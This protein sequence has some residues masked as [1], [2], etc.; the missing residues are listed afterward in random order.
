VASWL[1]PAIVF[2]GLSSGLL[3]ATF[4]YVWASH[5][6]RRYV[7]LWALAWLAAIPQLGATWLL[8]D[9]PDRGVWTCQQLLLTLNAFLM[10]AGC[11]DFVHS[12]AR[13]RRLF[14]W[15]LPFVLWAVFGP[16]LTD[17]FLELAL[18][19]ALLLAG[20][21]LWT[22][23]RF[24]GVSR[25]RDTRVA[26]TVGVLFAVAGLHELDFPLLGQS[27]WA[28]PIGYTVAS[29]LAISISVLLLVMILEE[30]RQEVVMERARL[31]GI[32][33]H[34]PVG[35]L[36]AG[37]HGEVVFVN[38]VAKNR[39]GP[40][41][42]PTTARELETRL[43][44]GADGALLEDPPLARVLATGSVHPAR[45]YLQPGSD[46]RL[47]AVAVNAAPLRDARGALIGAVAAFQDLDEIKTMQLEISRTE[48]LRGLG[49]VAAG[50]A[51]DFNNVL[52]VIVGHAE[53]AL[54]ATADAALRQPLLRIRD[55]AT[56]AAA[57]AKRLQNLARVRQGLDDAVV[58]LGGVVREAVEL[59]RPRWRDAAQE[60]GIAYDVRCELA[61]DVAAIVGDPDEL[62]E[63]VFNLVFNALDAMPGGGS[64]VC[65][66]TTEAGQAVLTLSDSGAGM[67]PAVL[68]RVFEPFFTTKGTGGTGLGLAVVF[69]IVERHDGT[70]SVTS[71]PGHGTTFTL[72]F[73]LVE[74]RRANV[75]ELTPVVTPHLRVLVVDDDAEICQLTAEM[76]VDEGHE[77]TTA[78]S[79]RQ[80]LQIV[81][82]GAPLDLVLTD[83]GMPQMNG[84]ELTAALRE[85]R[86]DLPVVLATGWGDS[87]SAEEATRQGARAILAK[88]FTTAKLLACIEGA[89][90][91]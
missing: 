76:L 63:V 46:G 75:V 61:S 72:R 87:A 28:A 69:G 65:R 15:A 78:G 79:G 16:V 23:S 2:M 68:D 84:W 73:P 24:I 22:A 53:L 11:Y 32:L 88:P 58:D 74:P 21:Y 62:R 30:S 41:G 80:A 91:R 3:A 54:R 7:L 19:N 17:R 60:R 90:R 35:V 27:V 81:S 43:F 38:E 8:L 64:L 25:E 39:C 26:R 42:P 5:V 89:I 12:G 36:V 82:D 56:T 29:F 1:K 44:R 6:R 66:L 86:P 83:L 37:L 9:L 71:Q 20:S 57:V 18:P 34:L 51:H 85:L 52:A 10:V 14:P 67:A 70:I 33:D 49:V 40:G 50:A 55:A 47:R 59:T 31:A 48:K 45:E 77:V 13:L 4:L